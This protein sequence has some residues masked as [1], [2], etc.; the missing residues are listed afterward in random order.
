MDNCTYENK[1]TLVHT[2]TYSNDDTIKE[3]QYLDL[4]GQR[5]LKAREKMLFIE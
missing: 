2:H 3:N 5:D 4:I 1:A